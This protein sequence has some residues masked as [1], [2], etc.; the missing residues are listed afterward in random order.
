MA[1]AT[2]AFNGAEPVAC[3]HGNTNGT[4]DKLTTVALF[5]WARAVGIQAN[6]DTDIYVTLTGTEDTAI[7]AN[8]KAGIARTGG[9][10]LVL[11]VTAGRPSTPQASILVGCASAS[12]GFVFT[13]FAREP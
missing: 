5:S 3:Y 2:S 9:G 7:G 8:L 11:P 13:Q 4:G 6:G 10:M 12:K 1:V